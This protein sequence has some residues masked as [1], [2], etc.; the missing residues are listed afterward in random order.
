MRLF[1]DYQQVDSRP[2]RGFLPKKH[3]IILFYAFPTKYSFGETHKYT[4][5]TEY[6]ASLNLS[7]RVET[8]AESKGDQEVL[9]HRV[10]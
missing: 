1:G 10:L 7:K 5:L 3:D 9:G 6:L 2:K 8:T 4:E